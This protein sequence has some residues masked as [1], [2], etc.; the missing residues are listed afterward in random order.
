MKILSKPLNRWG[1]VRAASWGA[2]AL[3]V[4]WTALA[5]ALRAAGEVPWMAWSG[6]TAFS[7]VDGLELA[8]VPL[9]LAVFAGWLE[10]HDARVET[11]QTTHQE[12]ERAAAARQKEIL[13]RFHEAVQ[14]GQNIEGLTREALAELDGKGK[15]AVLLFLFEKGLLSGEKPAVD[16]RG[17]DFR[18][19]R[20]HRLHL[21]GICLDSA[22]LYKAR[23]DGAHLPKSRL[24]GA[25]LSKALL[26]DANLR[27]ALLAE[28]NL[29]GAHLEGAHLEGA[30]LTG[31]HLKGT[32]LMDANLKGCIVEMDLLEQA[33]MI[34]TILPDGRKVTNA[35]GKA[36]LQNKEIAM[37]VDRL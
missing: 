4:L 16:L 23:M 14:G 31:A 18:E 10:E 17:A 9:L 33:V 7:P 25:N 22:D 15:G 11:E 3:C 28:S 36:Y 26:R 34:D 13:N 8:A 37:L 35:R 6:Y 21:S 32:L 20:A 24:C 5:A 19:A 29:T 1:W 30:D 2:L 27:G 12:A